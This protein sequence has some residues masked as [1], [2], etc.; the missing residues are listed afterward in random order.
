MA[1]YH[2]EEQG[3]EVNAIQGQRQER[4]G[5]MIANIQ[6]PG[7]AIKDGRTFAFDLKWMDQTMGT[8]DPNNINGVLADYISIRVANYYNYE[9]A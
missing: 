9:V 2:Q 7:H 8:E 1:D 5:Q 3:A 6:A 4:V